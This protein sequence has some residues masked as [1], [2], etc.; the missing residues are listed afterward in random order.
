MGECENGPALMT[1]Q[2]EKAAVM[3]V[4]PQIIVW[5]FKGAS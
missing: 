3:I 2:V 4:I 1:V 5:Q